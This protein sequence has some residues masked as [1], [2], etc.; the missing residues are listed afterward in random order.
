M[1][2]FLS[3]AAQ[4][5]V[6]KASF[7]NRLLGP[8]AVATLPQAFLLFKYTFMAITYSSDPI[9]WRMHTRRRHL[10]QYFYRVSLH[11][12]ASPCITTGEFKLALS[13]HRPGKWCTLPAVSL[14]TGHTCIHLV[15]QAPS[16]TT[17]M[18]ASHFPR[19]CPQTPEGLMLPLLPRGAQNGPV[20]DSH[21]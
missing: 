13:F 16:L 1:N 14:H 8:S 15:P 7:R 6:C 19:T 21:V 4:L 20:P 5:A 9:S 12:P 11:S 3:F 2:C 17:H 18:G 10:G